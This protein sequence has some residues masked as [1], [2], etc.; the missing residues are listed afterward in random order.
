MKLNKLL[1]RV[2]T[3]IG[4]YRFKFDIKQSDDVKKI[5]YPFNR[6]FIIHTTN[7]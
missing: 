7:K 4:K 6:K 2:K 1:R 5:K 3:K